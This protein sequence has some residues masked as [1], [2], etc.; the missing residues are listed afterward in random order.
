MDKL[1]RS[2]TPLDDDS[3]LMQM[4]RLVLGGPGDDGRA[5]YQIALSVCPECRRGHQQ[6][7]GELVP[8]GAEVV[9]MADCDGQH[10]GLLTPPL[11]N[12]G[13]MAH[14]RAHVG[15]KRSRERSEYQGDCPVRGKGAG[16]PPKRDARAK[17]TVT[18]ATRR[19]VLRRD[20]QRCAVPGCRNARFLDVHHIKLRSEGGGNEADNL[21]TLCGVHHRAAHRGELVVTG[22][23][24]TGV[25]FRH[26]D[27]S[28]YGRALE[29]RVAEIQAKAFL[30]LRGLG[31]R[32]GEVR[33]ALAESRK[34]GDDRQAS[35]ERVV[36]DALAELTPLRTN[37]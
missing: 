4:A 1:R 32:E 3:A 12:E 21:I 20:H 28:D 17:Q 34:R 35:I 36:R 16:T 5:S 8:V 10:L 18:P 19:A 25:R 6:A 24:S 23:V 7:S 14:E 37:S 15:A 22:S 9:A 31:F 33:R 2:G 29:P 26:A 27:G 11:A 13:S 30:A